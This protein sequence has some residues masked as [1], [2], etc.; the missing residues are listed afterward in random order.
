M[1]VADSVA[2]AKDA[3]E[4]VEIDYELLPAVSR[5]LDR[6]RAR[7]AAGAA[8]QRANIILDGEVGDAAA[9]DGGVR[10][11]P[12]ISCKLDTWVQRV[13]GV[14]ME[15][16]AALGEYDPATGRYT[17]LRRRWRRGQPAADL[18]H[19]ARRRRRARCAS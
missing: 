4:L 1:V 16:R 2:A 17:L 14:P 12:R 6:G 3:A 9:T 10:A 5:S 7:R 15:P 19:R 18:A 8:R 13:A 11:A